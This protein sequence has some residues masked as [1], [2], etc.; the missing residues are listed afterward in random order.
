MSVPISRKPPFLTRLSVVCL[1]ALLSFQTPAAQPITLP[2]LGEVARTTLTE[3]HE[4]RI[5]REIMRQIRDGGD[6]YS[7]PVILE[8][9]ARMGERLGGASPEPSKRFEF[10]AVRDPTLN[11]FALPGGYIGV[12]TGLL[13]ATRN[14]SELAGV[15]GHEMG[16]VTQQ[17]IARMVDAQKTNSLVSI[18]ALAVA[19]LAA[20]SNSEVTQAALTASQ[21]YSIQ[22]QLDFTRENEREADRIGLQTMAAAGYSP[23]GMSSFFERLQFQGRLYENNAPGYLRTHPLTY[24]RIADLENRLSQLPY[25]QHEDSLEY[26]FVRARVQAEEGEAAD[27]LRRFQA[28]TQ[29]H[30]GPGD[31]YGLARAALRANQ[32]EKAR[33]ALAQL[34]SQAS[35]SPLIALLD[36]EIELAAA[37]PEKAI[38]ILEPALRQYGGYRPLAYLHAEALLR[39]NR[40][41]EALRF[42]ETQQK[43]WSADVRFRTLSAQAYQSL[44]QPAQA[45]LAQAEAYALQ[46]RIV[47]AIDQLQSAQRQNDV[48]FYTQ[49]IVDARLREM[50]QRQTDEMPK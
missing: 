19:I 37:K 24:E 5:G 23:Q 10:F 25:H 3:S 35:Q 26:L 4:D 2:D 32:L 40:P 8:Y 41:A 45:H 21:A 30:P 50:R 11:A 13:S 33:Q 44:G 28:Q 34:R 27:A 16:H 49:S 17:H 46:D 47:A 38:A 36:G 48:D 9:L 14:E 42:V 15:L 18:L 39:A 20:R 43:L 22:S 1:C 31:W 7:D 29:D 6:Y 12:H